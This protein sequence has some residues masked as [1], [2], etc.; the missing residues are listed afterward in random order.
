MRSPA[1]VIAALS[2]DGTYD[3][4]CRVIRH[5]TRWLK[6]LPPKATLDQMPRKKA[7]Y[8]RM[9]MRLFRKELLD[10]AR[11]AAGRAS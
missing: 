8:V 6:R 7:A 1:D 9:R 2:T 3:D 11:A 4:W 5:F 10:V